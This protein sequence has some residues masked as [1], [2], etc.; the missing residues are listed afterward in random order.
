MVIKMAVKDTPTL[1]GNKLK[2]YYY[3]GDNYFELDVDVG[4][5]SVARCAVCHVFSSPSPPL[6]L[7]SSTNREIFS[8]PPPTRPTPQASGRTGHR[9]LQDHRGGHG[10]VPAR[11]RRVRA[12]RGRLR[13]LQVPAGRHERPC[14]QAAPVSPG[15]GLNSATPSVFPSHKRTTIMNDSHFFL[16]KQNKNQKRRLLMAFCLASNMLRAP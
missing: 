11:Q 8:P 6:F 4:S 5:S 7:S 3:R 16:P 14:V 13:R 15:L 10:P 1:L 9:L 2:Q 12:A